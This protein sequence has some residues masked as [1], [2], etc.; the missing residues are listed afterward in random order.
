VPDE[1]FAAKEV[2]LRTEDE[3]HQYAFV[4]F[5]RHRQEIDQMLARHRPGGLVDFLDASAGKPQRVD[6]ERTD[7]AAGIELQGRKAFGRICVRAGR[8]WDLQYPERGRITM[9]ELVGQ[10]A[11]LDQEGAGTAP[12]VLAVLREADFGQFRHGDQV[13]LFRSF[14]RWRSCRRRA[15]VRIWRET[16]TG[17]RPRVQAAAEFAASGEGKVQ[18]KVGLG[19]DL[20]PEMPP[21]L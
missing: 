20:L 8:R 10:M 5:D 17:E 6:E 4:G 1:I 12:H 3:C 9:A 18:R 13:A 16:E 15:G 14:R 21:P 7:A 11:A 2:A 19:D